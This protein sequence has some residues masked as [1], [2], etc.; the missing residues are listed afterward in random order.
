MVN[1]AFGLLV[2]SIILPVLGIYSACFGILI[3]TLYNAAGYEN[4]APVKF[5][6]ACNHLAYLHK[7]VGCRRNTAEHTFKHMLYL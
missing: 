2:L 7:L 3:C 6:L 5:L 1:K 4:V